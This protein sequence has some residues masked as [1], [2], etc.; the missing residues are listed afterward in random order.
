MPADTMDWS[1]AAYQAGIVGNQTYGM[2]GHEWPC[3]SP[4]GES[5]GLMIGL[6]GQHLRSIE[7]YLG[8]SGKTVA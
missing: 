4:G 8:I 7:Q 5:P 6:A 2:P 3:G 1:A